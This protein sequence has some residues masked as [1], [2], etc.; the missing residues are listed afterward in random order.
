MAANDEGRLVVAG[1]STFD[2]RRSLVAFAAAEAAARDAELRLLTA[3]PGPAAPDQYLPADPAP[4]YR[5]QAERQLTEMVRYVRDGLPGVA[6]S[7]DLA[8]GPPASVLRAAAENAALLVVGA[9]DASPFVEAISGSIPGDLL[10]TAPCPLAVVPRREWTTP[11]SA[12][13]VVALDGHGTSRAAV[14]Y[15]FA[16]AARAHRPLTAVHCLPPGPYD[17]S[18]NAARALAGF[19]E[20]YPDVA[21]E[22]EIVRG[23]PRYVLADASRD[24][25]L[26][27]LGSRGRGRLASGL[28]GSVSRHLIRESACP[29]VVARP[30]HESRQNDARAFG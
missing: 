25:A 20:Q 6:V 3:R 10:T 16:A 17:T 15:A 9:D 22:D 2:S 11:A 14:A 21:V 27:V 18:R 23:D 4:E 19:G 24:A 7:T 28:F 26:L 29:V 12:P 13:V 30:N 8:T 5:A 1:V